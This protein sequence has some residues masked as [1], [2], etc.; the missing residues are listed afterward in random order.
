MMQKNDDVV[1][2]SS[3]DPDIVK[4]VLRSFFSLTFLKDLVYGFV[5]YLLNHV[6]GLIRVN[7]G[8]NVKIRP[9]VMLRDPERIYI[10][11]NASL[12]IHNVLWAGKKDAIIKIGANVMTGPSVKIFAFNHGMEI[13]QG[14]MIDQ[15]TTEADIII[16]DDVWI[17][18][19]VLIMPGCT[20]GSGC[21]IAAGSVVVKDIPANSIC[22]GVPAKIIKERN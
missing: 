12:G 2:E 17:G 13:D 6:Y 14:P 3:D 15:P 5:F 11:D 9:H 1:E 8:K 21:V 10:G 19:N 22:A 20:I 4:K 18:A 7:K 16:E